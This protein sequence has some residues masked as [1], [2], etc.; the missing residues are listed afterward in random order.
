MSQFFEAYTASVI[1][2]SLVLSG[3]ISPAALSAGTTDDYSPPGLSNVARLR[4]TTNVSGSTLGGLAPQ[5]DGFFLVVECL[6]L[7]DLT[8]G[9]ETLTS[10]ATF[11]FALPSDF[12]IP[13]DYSQAIIYEL[14]DQRW[15]IA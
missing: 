11:R 5:V 4:I 10:T 9:D 2:G 12:V 7:G 6:G 14:A 13:P 3:S 15:R 1:P 8:L